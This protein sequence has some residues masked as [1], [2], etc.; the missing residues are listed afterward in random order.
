MVLVLVR[1]LVHDQP[2]LVILVDRLVLIVLVLVVHIK[3]AQGPPPIEL[4]A[5]LIDTI[6]IEPVAEV[7]TSG[8]SI[9]PR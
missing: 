1:L 8:T 9:W 4:G 3:L 6:T 2:T 5:F 7:R